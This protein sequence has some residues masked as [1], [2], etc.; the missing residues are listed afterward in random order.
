M[1]IVI[2]L[3]TVYF[4]Y[5]IRKACQVAHFL[6]IKDMCV[7][8]IFDISRRYQRLLYHQSRMYLYTLERYVLTHL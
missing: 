8:L 1:F 2:M 6:Y 4:F 7:Y 3:Y 5:L